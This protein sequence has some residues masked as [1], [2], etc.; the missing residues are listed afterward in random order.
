[1]S[2]DEEIPCQNLVRCVKHEKHGTGPTILRP[3]EGS[4]FSPFCSH[5]RK[6]GRTGGNVVAAL[7]ASELSLSFAGEK[8]AEETR[9]KL[10]EAANSVNQ[11]QMKLFRAGQ[12]PAAKSRILWSLFSSRS[13]LQGSSRAIENLVSFTSLMNDRDLEI[14]LSQIDASFPNAEDFHRRMILPLV[15]RGVAR[16]EKMLYLANMLSKKDSS[17]DESFDRSIDLHHALSEAGL[18]EG[19]VQFLASAIAEVK[20]DFDLDHESAIGYATEKHRRNEASSF[21]IRLNPLSLGAL[22]DDLSSLKV[23]MHEVGHTRYNVQGLQESLFKAFSDHPKVIS[24][25]SS[26]SSLA[27]II[28]NACNDVLINDRIDLENVILSLPDESGSGWM[29]AEAGNVMGVLGAAIAIGPGVGTPRGDKKIGISFATKQS[30]KESIP[31]TKA[32][33]ET[34][35]RFHGKD[36]LKTPAVGEAFVRDLS[37]EIM[38]LHLEDDIFQ[39]GRKL[40]F[41]L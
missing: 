9:Q 24:N 32:I 7:A 11:D 41:S 6:S 1:M 20:I 8:G 35:E 23:I 31:E 2:K 26:I 27:P 37:I 16:L 5:C 10:N 30:M 4:P 39:K 28:R 18:S 17:E 3:R 40:P 15:E 12:H 33:F 13:K 25:P 36:F 34:A 14:M 29:D 22:S 38:R 19:D 21:D